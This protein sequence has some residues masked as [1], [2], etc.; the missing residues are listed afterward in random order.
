M[1]ELKLNDVRRYAIATRNIV[2]Y[3][4]AQGRVAVLNQK[5]VVEI[6]EISG[7]PPYNVEEVFAGAVSFRLEPWSSSYGRSVVR[8]PKT[9]TR[10]QMVEEV[11]KILPG[12]P[13][14]GGHEEE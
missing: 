8:A 12:T 13:K 4:D 5:G 11:R 1:I 3:T 9:L 2:R 7:P 14:T 10:E 6:P